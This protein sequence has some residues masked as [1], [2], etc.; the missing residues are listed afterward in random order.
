MSSEPRAA[1]RHK[2]LASLWLK[3][4]EEE[5]R[6]LAPAL[7]C[8]R[9]FCLF[10]LF[11]CLFGNYWDLV[12]VKGGNFEKDMFEYAGPRSVLCRRAPPTLLGRSRRHLRPGLLATCSWPD[13]HCPLSS[14]GP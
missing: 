4:G 14:H 1:S 8:T 3:T 5:S 11:V 9:G 10:R 7:S 2:G 12:L 13:L 6:L